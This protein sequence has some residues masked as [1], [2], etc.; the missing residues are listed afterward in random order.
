MVFMFFFFSFNDL[1]SKCLQ[2]TMCM[3]VGVCTAWIRECCHISFSSSKWILCMH[4][5]K[6]P[7]EF[8]SVCSSYIFWLKLVY[9]HTY[10]LIWWCSTSTSGV[11]ELID[12]L[13]VCVWSIRWLCVGVWRVAESHKALCLLAAFVTTETCARLCNRNFI[14]A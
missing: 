10:T 13:C 8:E 11:R 7:A 4:L 9:T 6:Q 5:W 14:I 1:L 3:T 12:L 2:C